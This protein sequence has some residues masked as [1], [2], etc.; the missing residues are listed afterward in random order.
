MSAQQ[1]RG[2]KR[3]QPPSAKDTPPA[4]ETRTRKKAREA[5]D[6]MSGT[7]QRKK[8]TLNLFHEDLSGPTRQELVMMFRVFDRD[9][10][11]HIS[12]E[13]L[14]DV[15][16]SM[17]KR[18]L[19]RKIQKIFEEC[20]TDQNGTIELEEFVT[21]M[22]KKAQ[23]KR[24]AKQTKKA[25]KQAASSSDASS[26]TTTTTSNDASS[27]SSSDDDDAPPTLLRRKSSIADFYGLY[28][29]T[30][31]VGDDVTLD[32][33][34][35]PEG[36]EFDL[37][38]E[39]AFTDFSVIV[40]EFY[41]IQ[42]FDDTVGKALKAKGF[43]YERANSQK[44]FIAK[45]NNASVAWIISGHS[46]D[47]STT[48]QEFVNAVID[49]HVSGGGLFIWTDN[50]PYYAQAN[51]L[52]NY[53]FKG[54]TF[55]GNTPG[56]KVLKVGARNQPVPVSG[57]FAPHLI[58]TGLK[59]LYEGHSICYFQSTPSTFDVLAT[60][61]DGHPVIMYSRRDAF[62]ITAGRVMIDCGFTKLYLQYDTAGTSRYICN[63]CVW[64]LGLDHRI[65]IDA[66]L[67]GRVA[68]RRTEKK[69][70]W[71][72]LHGSWMR[73]DEDASDM[74][75]QAYQAYL[76]NPVTDVRAVKSGIWHYQIDFTRMK[77]KNI[78]HHAHTERDIRRV[79]ADVVVSNTTSTT[80]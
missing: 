23:E 49:F 63:A 60:S 13:E 41:P 45:L 7:L 43:S 72:Y 56:Q 67:R 73:Y 21:Y 68:P 12:S 38:R 42:N 58:S 19:S 66:P 55:Q 46:L 59:H 36:T 34:Q 15:M 32:Q 30:N 50:D 4:R 20:D 18:P 76:K 29:G 33:Y 16:R 74:V 64:L 8:S 5:M 44:D 52:S 11:G 27:S 78:E 1:T 61:T 25:K 48:P 62:P 54:E 26:S 40:G 10:D 51:L 65:A 24:E 17:G 71:E 57:T 14:K 39:G 69:W 3:K 9:N 37:G 2:T 6:V 77:Q 47:S 35:N 70:V 80:N 31:E 75:E 79:Q 53:L 28:A 22:Q